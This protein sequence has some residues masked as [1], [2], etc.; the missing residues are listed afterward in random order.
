MENSYR[1]QLLS[2]G[3]DLDAFLRVVIGIEKRAASGFRL[4]NLQVTAIHGMEK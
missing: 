2:N 4:L 1:T 3:A